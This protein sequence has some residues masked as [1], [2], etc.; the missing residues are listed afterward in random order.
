MRF[1]GIRLDQ[2][3]DGLLAAMATRLGRSSEAVIHVSADEGEDIGELAEALVDAGLLL[4]AEPS[5]ALICDGCE[6]NCVMLVNVVQSI[7]PQ[8][9]RAF[10]VCDKRHD[11]SRVPVEAARLR[12][13]TFSLTILAASLAKALRTNQEPAASGTGDSWRLGS[14][15]IGGNAI[16]VT[17]TRSADTI[18]KE[19][20]LAIILTE[21]DSDAGRDQWITLGSAF[22]VRDGQI[23]PRAHVLRTALSSRFDDPTIGIAAE[24]Y[25][26]HHK[27]L[28]EWSGRAGETMPRFWRSSPDGRRRSAGTDLPKKRKPRVRALREWYK[29]RVLSFDKSGKHPSREDDYRDAKAEFGDGVTHDVIRS[30]RAE[31]ALHWTMKGRPSKKT[32]EN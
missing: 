21:P 1:M 32:G 25:L 15:N 7:A 13:W 17:L 2:R 4:P 6:R 5:S 30:I 22:F 3:L 10:I 29:K 18:P 24:K 12:R 16:Q 8:P 28:A 26:S 20:Q 31:L 19:A 23:V 9:A 11:I 27:A 14:T